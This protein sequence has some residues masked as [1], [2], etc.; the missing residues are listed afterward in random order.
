MHRRRVI[1]QAHFDGFSSQHGY[2][3]ATLRCGRGGCCLPM[4]ESIQIP[5]FWRRWWR[6]LHCVTLVY[7]FFSEGKEG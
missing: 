2:V 4:A 3:S 6:A 7:Y 5:A 1:D